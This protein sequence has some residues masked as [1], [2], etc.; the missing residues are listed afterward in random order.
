M[1]MFFATQATGR[2]R[3]CGVGRSRAVHP[4]FHVGLVPGRPLWGRRPGSL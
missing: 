4:T 2:F 1:G 3:R